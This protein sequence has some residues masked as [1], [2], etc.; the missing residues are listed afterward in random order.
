MPH[1]ALEHPPCF[2]TR[3]VFSSCLLTLC[4][5]LFS[6]ML[7]LGCFSRRPNILS[8]AQFYL[9]FPVVVVSYGVL[10]M[11]FRFYR[12]ASNR[13]D[14]T[15]INQHPQAAPHTYDHPKIVTQPPPNPPAST[16]PHYGRLVKAHRR[17][18]HLCS[19]SCSCVS[20]LL[21]RFFIFIFLVC[22]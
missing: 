8:T 13:L 18:T 10:W 21:S 11:L 19:V 6:F 20:G 5:A 16:K 2:F 14:F 4:D 9:L 7:H 17:H 15:V 3:K 12:L 22:N 1:T